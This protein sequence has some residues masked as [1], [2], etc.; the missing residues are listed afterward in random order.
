MSL[1][2]AVEKCMMLPSPFDDLTKLLSID[3]IGSTSGKDDGTVATEAS[4][5]PAVLSQKATVIQARARGMV[6][7]HKLKTLNREE[8]ALFQTRTRASDTLGAGGKIDIGESIKAIRAILKNNKEVW[9]RCEAN[10]C[11]ESVEHQRTFIRKGF[12][13]VR[14]TSDS[15]KVKFETKSELSEKTFDTSVIEN[16]PEKL[17]G[18]FQV[19]YDDNNFVNFDAFVD[20]ALLLHENVLG[21]FLLGLHNHLVKVQ[22]CLF[23]IEA[24]LTEP[25]RD[26]KYLGTLF[27]IQDELKV[28]E[29]SGLVAEL[30]VRELAG[31]FQTTGTFNIQESRGRLMLEKLLDFLSN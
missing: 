27:M 13:T 6:I 19:H 11:G 4:E 1:S 2:E 23:V 28:P 24:W 20:K 18:I 29:E 15:N 30:G 9:D 3:V 17:Q 8:F 16:L 7:R 25:T 5:D 12:V 21:P 26:V 31:D 22:E 10:Q 14:A